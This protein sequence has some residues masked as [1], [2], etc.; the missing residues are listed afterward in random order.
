M[1]TCLILLL[2]AAAP[3]PLGIHWEVGRTLAPDLARRTETSFPLAAAH[4]RLEVEAR[5]AEGAQIE[6]IVWHSAGWGAPRLLA[7]RT[8]PANDPGAWVFLRVTLDR[9]L[10]PVEV[11]GRTEAPAPA[12]SPPPSSPAETASASTSSSPSVRP[13]RP[14]MDQTSGLWTRASGRMTVDDRGAESGLEFGV[15]AR[16]RDRWTLGVDLGFQRRELTA[17]SSI[18]QVPLTVRGGYQ[19]LSPIAVGLSLRGEIMAGDP[20]AGFGLHA[21][22]WISV[23]HR[24]FEREWDAL[25]IGVLV[26]PQ[27]GLLRPSLV[28]IE[29]STWTESPARVAATVYLEWAWQ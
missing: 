2:A 29:G 1:P 10:A 18:F 14:L 15:G 3:A 6:L 16:F 11:S 25:L 7:R 22:A 8:F 4:P 20:G 26:E 24:F 19:V 13:W 9:H 27:V 23:H 12:P 28:D 5:T 21:G 17:V